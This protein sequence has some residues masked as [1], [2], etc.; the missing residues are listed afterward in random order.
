MENAER[1]VE[2]EVAQYGSPK[3]TSETL[4]VNGGNGGEV[5]EKAEDSKVFRCAGSPLCV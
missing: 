4:L 2:G 3:D 1:M 5:G